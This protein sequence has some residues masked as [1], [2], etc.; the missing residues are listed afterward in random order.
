LGTIRKGLAW[1]EGEAKKRFGKGFAAAS[2]EQ[3]TAI[4]EDIVK[5]GTPAR[6]AAG[7]FFRTFRDRAAAGYYSTREGWAAIGY[8][9]NVPLAEFP[10]PPPEALKHLG[11]A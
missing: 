3:Q 6:K 2:L 1:I 7:G 9:G 8:V 5:E 10:G 4:V 11:L